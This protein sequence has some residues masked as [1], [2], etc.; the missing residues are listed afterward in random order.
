MTRSLVLSFLFVSASQLS[1]QDGKLLERTSYTVADSSIAKWRARM[2]EID[3]ILNGVRI[4][5][6][7]YLSDR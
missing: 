4:S 1:A 3:T 6:I 2:P 7:T 5:R